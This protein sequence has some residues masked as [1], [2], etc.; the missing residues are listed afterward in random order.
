MQA[1]SLPILVGKLDLLY[2]QL[3]E[4][5]LWASTCKQHATTV[6]PTFV[7]KK[8]VNPMEIA[9]SSYY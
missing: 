4:I 6:I 3:S 8:W 9:E 7:N 2:R 5:Q 1:D